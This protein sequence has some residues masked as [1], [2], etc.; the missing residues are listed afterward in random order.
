VAELQRELQQRGLVTEGLKAVLVSRLLA[1]LEQE[2]L[3]VQESSSDVTSVNPLPSRCA[4]VEDG[5][6]GAV[7]PSS[8]K[9]Q[10]PLRPAASMQ[11][12]PRNAVS[13][14]PVRDL[15]QAD[16]AF[17]GIAASAGPTSMHTLQTFDRPAKSSAQFSRLPG[18]TMPGSWGPAGPTGLAVTWLGTS[19]GAPSSVRNVSSMAFHVPG[20]TYLVDAGEGTFNQMSR[21][22]LEPGRIKG[23]AGWEPY[24]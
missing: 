11:A 15:M 14:Q 9:A 10:T 12:P 18:R 6:E 7:S 19:S 8:P 2:V 23:C 22:R 16:D 20:G 13:Q 17:E 24:P 3:A 1:A 5:G 4:D 21:A